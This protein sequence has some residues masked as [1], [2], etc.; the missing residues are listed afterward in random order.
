MERRTFR[1]EVFNPAIVLKFVSVLSKIKKRS[2]APY[3]EG[4]MAMACAFKVH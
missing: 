3:V 4:S 1:G 2:L